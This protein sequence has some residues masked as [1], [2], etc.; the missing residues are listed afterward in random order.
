M[1]P[2][3]A[4]SSY[5]L[6]VFRLNLISGLISRAVSL[7]ISGLNHRNIFCVRI[8]LG[9]ADMRV[10]M[11]V[12]CRCI[13][14]DNCGSSMDFRESGAT[15]GSFFIQTPRRVIE[16][17]GISRGKNFAGHLPN[18]CPIYL[19]VCHVGCALWRAA[20]EDAFRILKGSATIK[21]SVCLRHRVLQ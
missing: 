14:N 6:I 12:T 5:R 11:C 7:E 15:Q 3:M 10:C 9:L 13:G 20:I 8:F 2:S 21:R 1:R 17:N 4:I 19:S 16:T 18:R